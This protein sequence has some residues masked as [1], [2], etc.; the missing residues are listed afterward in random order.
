MITLADLD[1][2]GSVSFEKKAM[3]SSAIGAL[4]GAGAGLITGLL[5]PKDKDLDTWKELLYSTLLGAALG[6]AGG[7]AYDRI[8]GPSV[9][10][11][12]SSSSSGGSTSAGDKPAKPYQAGNGAVEN[13][14]AGSGG[15]NAPGG[16]TESAP[17][18]P[19]A[20]QG[21]GAVSVSGDATG[22]QPQGAAEEQAEAPKPRE[23]PDVLYD[24]TDAQRQALYA[25]I[26]GR[27][28]PI[29]LDYVLKKS[30][31]PPEDDSVHP[32]VPFVLTQDRFDAL[33]KDDGVV[34]NRNKDVARSLESFVYDPDSK[35]TPVPIM[36]Y[37]DQAG[38]EYWL[39]GAVSPSGNVGFSFPDGTGYDQFPIPV[40]NSTSLGYDSV[41]KTGLEEGKNAINVG[42]RWLKNQGEAAGRSVGR[43]VADGV[44]AATNAVSNAASDAYRSSRDWT[45]R[46]GQALGSSF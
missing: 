42:W 10:S 18:Q 34:E 12:S 19:G 14:Q 5:R 44:S 13:A 46:Q 28:K 32:G 40:L 21:A 23:Y 24:F 41:A 11:S 36:F 31:E 39:A 16:K 25:A 29:P 35:A 1:T 3:N 20:T 33:L 27:D 17:A 38:N 15:K 2:F 45:L 22:D 7:Y 9:S 26:D 6:G 37:R 43:S 30:L 4:G 8:A